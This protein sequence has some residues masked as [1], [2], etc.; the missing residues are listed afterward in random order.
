[1]YQQP[2][3]SKSTQHTQ[4]ILEANIKKNWFWRSILTFLHCL[5]LSQAFIENW[6]QLLK[7]DLIWPQSTNFGIFY[8]L[9]I[10]FHKQILIFG[11]NFTYEIF[12][13]VL[14]KIS[15]SQNETSPK[16]RTNE[17]VFLSWKTC[18]AE[19]SSNSNLSKHKHTYTIVQDNAFLLYFGR[20]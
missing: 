15:R 4:H 9:F 11:L 19:R 1:M 7:M 2:A 13:K 17:F 20:S 3:N 14:L 16:K 12:N 10:H 5:T 18:T 6:Y 8:L